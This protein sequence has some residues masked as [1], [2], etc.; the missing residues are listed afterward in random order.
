MRSGPRNRE[1]DPSWKDS[2]PTMVSN[3]AGGQGYSAQPRLI[4]SHPGRGVGTLPA[5]HADTANEHGAGLSGD[6]LEGLDA[7]QDHCERQVAAQ[8]E[9][10]TA[11][12]LGVVR[13]TAQRGGVDRD[14]GAS[15]TQV[16]PLGFGQGVAGANSAR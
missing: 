9:P 16:G 2:S 15:D 11:R 13:V 10:A 8:R 14:W 1:A 7:E 6:G 3:P 12:G 4:R 5:E